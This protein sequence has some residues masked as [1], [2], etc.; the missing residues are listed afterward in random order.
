MLLWRG[1]MIMNF[2]IYSWKNDEFFISVEEKINEIF[3]SGE[4]KKR[5]IAE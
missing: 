1:K 5:G 4:E 3:I 2:L